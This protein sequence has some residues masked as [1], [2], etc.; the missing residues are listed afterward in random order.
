[1]EKLLASS[2]ISPTSS[3]IITFKVRDFLFYE[4]YAKILK[5]FFNTFFSKSANILSEI[6]FYYIYLQL[7]FA[8]K[9]DKKHRIL[10]VIFKDSDSEFYSSSFSNELFEYFLKTH[11]TKME[12]QILKLLLLDIEMIKVYDETGMDSVFINERIEGIRRKFEKFIKTENYN[13]KNYRI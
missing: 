9:T 10:N 1:M 4:K 7:K 12:N 2:N 11:L 6:I 13:L 3:I 5:K 8:N